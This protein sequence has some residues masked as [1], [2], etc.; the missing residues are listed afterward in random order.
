MALPKEPRQKMINLMY[1]VLTALLALNVSS[2]ILNAFKTVNRSLINSNHMIDDKNKGVFASFEQK[3][4]AKETA[5]LAA[6]WK[7]KADEAGKLGEDMSNYL[8]DLKVQLMKAAGQTTP[9]GPFKE[10]NLDA[11]THLFLTE[12]KGK[13]LFDRLTKYK[14]DLLNVDSSVKRDFQNSLPIDLTTPPSNNEASQKE[15][16]YGYFHMTPT[17]AGITMLSKFENDVKNSEALVVDYL[18]RKIGEVQIVYDAFQAFAGTNSQYLMPGQELVVTAGVG[19]FSKNALPTVLI[20]GV[21]VPLNKD[22]AAEYKTKVG[23]PGSYTK[24]VTV[25]F[26]KP[27]GTPST[28][29]RKIEYSVGSPTGASVSADAVKVLYIGLENPLT[30]LGGSAGD[31]KTAA[32]MDGG[33]LRKTGPGKYI[34][35]VGSP[36][37]ATINVSVETEAGRKSTAFE[38]R[39]KRVPDPIA[40]V[41]ASSG[42]RT[43]VNAFKAQSGVRADLRDFV[44]EGVKFDVVSYVVYATGAGF[45]ENPGISQNGGPVFNDNSRRVIEK[46]R[47]GSTV[48]IDEIKARGP[49]GDTRPLPP[50]A[51]N[52]F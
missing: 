21:N 47:P 39:V 14:N 10:D 33:N 3:L 17:I 11:A 20:D 13:E 15:W 4:K 41:G 44:F 37:K 12:T 36:G 26:K 29:T 35:T 52:L 25:N 34:A 51:F 49:G 19:A 5:E 31:E 22:G 23:G 1:L 40:M 2:E 43:P 46:C 8:E 24:T 30:I 16:A 32:S 6:K 18:H 7:P 50:M 9:G 48:V 27:D 28:E 38:F 45:S 42:G